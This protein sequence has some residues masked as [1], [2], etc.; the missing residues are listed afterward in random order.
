MRC[1]YL[2]VTCEEAS[3]IWVHSQQQTLIQSK[4]YAAVKIGQL[5]GGL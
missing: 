1:A 2:V 4:D 5:Y 3:R